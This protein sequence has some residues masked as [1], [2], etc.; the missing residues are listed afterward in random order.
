MEKSAKSSVP[1]LFAL[2]S[3]EQDADADAAGNALRRIDAAPA[4]SIPMLLKVVE[5]QRA[6]QR[7]RYY[8]LHLLK[9]A[10]PAARTALP[11]LRQLAGTAEGR[12]RDFL[13]SAIRD[14]EALP[15][16]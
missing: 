8:A 1:A 4:D 2:L 7:Q 6:S 14:I 15:E 12:S 9:K 3:S 16:G 5:D 10:G 13:R 11:V